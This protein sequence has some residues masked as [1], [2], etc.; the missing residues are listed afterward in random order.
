[1]LPPAFATVGVDGRRRSYHESVWK[2]CAYH[3]EWG[4]LGRGGHV[5]TGVASLLLLRCCILTAAVHTLGLYI[6]YLHECVRARAVR[7]TAWFESR[8][9]PAT[10]WKAHIYNN[11]RVYRYVNTRT[12]YMYTYVC[13]TRARVRSVSQRTWRHKHVYK[14]KIL[15]PMENNPNNTT[16]NQPVDYDCRVNTIK[17]SSWESWNAR[18][19]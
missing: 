15:N 10:S 6:I 17:W 16:H 13:N 3:K 11:T 4:G 18:R 2:S 14:T 9:T 19:H 8:S 5:I 1:M 12:L 7:S